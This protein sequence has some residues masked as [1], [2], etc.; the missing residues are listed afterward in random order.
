MPELRRDCVVDGDACTVDGGG[1]PRGGGPRGG[2][3]LPTGTTAAAAKRRNAAGA[4]RTR[5]LPGRRE[6]EATSDAAI[7]FGT[8]M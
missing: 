5:E 4:R 6:N 7:H 3:A 1:G 8:I 2:A